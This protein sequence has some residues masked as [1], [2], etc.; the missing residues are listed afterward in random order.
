MKRNKLFIVAGCGLIA[1]TLLCGSLLLPKSESVIAK[2]EKPAVVSEEP[3]KDEPR[4]KKELPSETI[5][6]KPTDTVREVVSEVK[7]VS[8]P[9]SATPPAQSVSE[10]QKP[11][12][13]V[14][15]SNN[16]SQLSRPVKSGH[17][18]DKWVEDSPAYDEEEYK[19]VGYFVCNG[20]G[21]DMGQDESL[22]DSHGREAMLSGN[23]ACGSWKTLYKSVPAGTIHHDAVGH[24]EKVWVAD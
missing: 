2:D 1:C 13:Q 4:P 11:A 18:E 24:Y 9:K 19:T 23:Y 3:K 14:A 7:A 12:E 20:C 22:L 15:S 8:N 21:L 5:E 6:V 16:S 17:Y 10:P